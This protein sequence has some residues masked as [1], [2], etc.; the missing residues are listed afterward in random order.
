MSLPLSSPP[1]PLLSITLINSHRDSV[2]EQELGDDQEAE[3]I[4]EATN[5]D[6]EDI[7]TI[8]ID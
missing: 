5:T 3:E 7:L 6:V 8:S 1:S 2:V 4:A